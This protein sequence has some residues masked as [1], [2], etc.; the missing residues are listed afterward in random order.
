MDLVF[1][2]DGGGT[3]CRA[4]VADLSGRILGRAAAGPAN[5]TTDPDGAV[6]HIIEAAHAALA[7]AGLEAAKIARIPAYLGLAGHNIE[8]GK[9]GIEKRLPFPDCKLEDDG[10]IALQG[11]LGTAEGIVAVLGTGSVYLG[12]RGPDIKRVG[13]W[14]FM[15]GDLGSGARLGR[16]LLQ[17]TLLAY[18]NIMPRSPLTRRVMSDFNFDPSLLVQSAQSEKPGGFGRFAPLVFEYAEKGDIVAANLV[19]GAV[20]HVDAALAAITWPGCD[21]LAL[22]GGLARFYAPRIDAQFRAILREPEG[23][24]LDGAVQLAIRHFHPGAGGAQ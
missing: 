7:D 8:A 10:A 14:G 19:R 11:A 24:A 23:D 6:T 3:S 5:T 21:R 17:D 13:G 1:G 15:V 2:F 12:R 16:A 22:L 4:A 9:L 20:A 18:D